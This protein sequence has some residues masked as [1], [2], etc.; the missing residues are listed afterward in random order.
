M[1]QCF[2][3][4]N[5]NTRTQSDASDAPK[6]GI[7]FI[8]TW[9]ESGAEYRDLSLSAFLPLSHRR[10]AK[11][12]ARASVAVL[13]ELLILHRLKGQ[14]SSERSNCASVRQP[15]ATK[16]GH[17][18]F[19][20][21]TCRIAAASFAGSNLGSHSN[22]S[23]GLA[24]DQLSY[25]VVTMAAI[26]SECLPRRLGRIEGRC[27]RWC[28]RRDLGPGQLKHQSWQRRQPPA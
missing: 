12:L 7:I 20:A 1:Q 14:N 8:R 26:R 11:V 27:A 2:R 13:H 23:A 17:G 19:V 5:H 15:Q 3:I 28:V 4:Y 18:G 9:S 25:H 10:P 21:L 6:H 16:I 22:G 24:P